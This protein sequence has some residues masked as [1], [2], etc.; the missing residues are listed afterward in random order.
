MIYTFWCIASGFDDFYYRVRLIKE[1]VMRSSKP[2][3]LLIVDDKKVFRDVFRE[4]LQSNRRIGVIEEA[5]SA[6]QLFAMIDANGKLP[7]LIF[8]D[9]QLPG[10]N[11]FEATRK[12]LKINPALKVI[13]SLIEVTL[14]K[15][16]L[17]KEAG[18]VGW[19]AKRNVVEDVETLIKKFERKNVNQLDVINK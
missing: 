3:N 18:A 8:I 12:L 13:I 19:I 17:A 2:L 9:E 14:E 15:Q 10:I 1:K 4:T 7:D 16:A 11:G 5:E 6:E